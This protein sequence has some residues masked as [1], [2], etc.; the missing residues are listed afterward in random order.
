MKYFHTIGKWTH[1]TA[2]IF[3]HKEGIPDPD[4]LSLFISSRII[5]LANR[6]IQEELQWAKGKT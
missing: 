3:Q 6:E 2:E 4:T 5:A 1:V